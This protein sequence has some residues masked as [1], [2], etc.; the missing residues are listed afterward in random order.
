M[1]RYCCGKSE[2]DDIVVSFFAACKIRHIVVNQNKEG[3]YKM[4]KYIQLEGFVKSNNEAVEAV[5][6]H[7]VEKYKIE[8]E[9]IKKYV[10]GVTVNPE[11]TYYFLDKIYAMT[12]TTKR[13]QRLVYVHVAEYC[14]EKLAGRADIVAVSPKETT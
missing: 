4:Q 6:Q 9:T 12:K 13:K 2:R 8:K 10:D 1:S 5:V 14:I 7:L 11:E 3:R